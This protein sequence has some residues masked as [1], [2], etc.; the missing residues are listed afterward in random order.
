MILYPCPR[1][2][3]SFP[4]SLGASLSNEYQW[5]SN[6][7]V[8]TYYIYN[9]W[10]QLIELW[11]HVRFMKGLKQT[12]QVVLSLPLVLTRALFSVC[13]FSLYSL[14]FREPQVTYKLQGLQRQQ[15]SV[16]TVTGVDCIN[17]LTIRHENQKTSH[18]MFC[19]C[20]RQT[21]LCELYDTGPQPLLSSPCELCF[22]SGVT[23]SL[24]AP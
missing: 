3:Q 17:I 21:L 23:W 24:G 12:C 5:L 20:K 1:T 22:P 18:H 8:Q 9:V 10:L 13:L 6:F 15:S 19:S 14:L 11:Q 16:L 2:S 4:L 7:C